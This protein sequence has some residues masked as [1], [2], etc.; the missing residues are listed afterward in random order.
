MSESKEFVSV[1]PNI[2]PIK[3]PLI[4]AFATQDTILLMEKHINCPINHRTQAAHTTTTHSILTFT[5][6]PPRE[7]TAM[8]PLLFSD[9]TMTL[10]VSILIKPT[11]DS[12]HDLDASLL[13]IS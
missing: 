7:P 6:L 8:D 10:L 2:L 9:L 5:T 12:Y 11:D 4:V 3:Q 13:L 1:A